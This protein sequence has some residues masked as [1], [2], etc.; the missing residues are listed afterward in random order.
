VNAAPASASPA[1][2]FLGLSPE[3]SPRQSA[4]FVLV[5][6]PH[7]AT[8]AGQPGC[9]LGPEAI[10]RASQTLER[11]DSELNIEAARIGIHTAA[12][13]EPA[14]E[15]PGAM[16]ARIREVVGAI[17]AEDKIPFL[18]G[19]EHTVTTAAVETALESATPRLTV[20][21]IDAH[22]DL[23]ANHHGSELSSVSA[24]RRLLG[25]VRLVQV[26]VRSCSQEESEA[27]SHEM[28]QTFPMHA[29]RRRQISDVIA[30]IGQA[31]RGE[32][33]ISIDLSGLDPSIMPSTAR[34]EPGGLLWWELLAILR[35]VI[36]QTSVV[37]LDVV[38]LAPIPGLAAPNILAAQ[39]VQKLIGYTVKYQ[40][41]WR[42]GAK[43]P[44]SPTRPM[45]AAGAD[46]A[47]VRM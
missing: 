28:V 7:E 43:P 20:L 33:H 44:L 45:P 26:G 30:E 9:R 12:P 32:V 5:P 40:A 27:A 22:S 41:F 46:D 8:A 6:V 14:G 15:G 47:T 38:E 16:W 35:A 10:L 11:F 36:S 19:G 3:E 34:P 1:W 21:Q 23:R 18:I 29:I 42:R 17:Y 24:M 25:R 4:R 31:V 39:L 37:G 13:I 2:S